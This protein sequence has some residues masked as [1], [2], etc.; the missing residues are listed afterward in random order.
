MKDGD[1]PAGR[2]Q[3]WW[4]KMVAEGCGYTLPWLDLEVGEIQRYIKNPKDEIDE[5]LGIMFPVDILANLEGKEVLCLASGGGQQSVVFSLLGARVTVVD[6]SPGQLAGDREAAAH[7]DYQITT[8][9]AD[10]R[11]LSFFEEAS[12]DLVYQ[13][14]SMSYVPAVKDVYGEVARV[15]KTGGL[16]RVAHTNPAVE[17][18]ETDT[19]DGEG[20]RISLP[21]TVRKVEYG[22]SG[23]IQFRHY[24]GE[25]FNGLLSAG[26]SVAWVGE[27]PYH[28]QVS[29]KTTPGTWEHSQGY[30][31]WIFAVVAKKD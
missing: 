31:P 2:N 10:M 25:I 4:E 5:R 24:L 15:L 22:E 30:I 18:I 13:A 26:L 28:F 11:D 3:D 21:Y 9:Q 14:P 20:Y 27:A 8:F 23:S 6:L 19:W 1:N 7:Y 17:F 29:S 16:Y 12:F